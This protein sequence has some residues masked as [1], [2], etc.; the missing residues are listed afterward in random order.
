MDVI[1]QTASNG[2]GKSLEQV[3]SEGY[4]FNF[5]NYMSKGFSLFGNDA[6]MY[7]AYALLYLVINMIVGSIPV[8][9]IFG[10][11]ALSPALTVGWYIYARNHNL[12]ATRSFNNFFEGFNRNWV[13]LI[14]QNIIT[15]IFVGVAAAIVIVPFFLGSFV[16]LIAHA[17][18]LERAQGDQEAAMQILSQMLSSGVVM[19]ILLGGLVALAVATLYVYAPMFIVFRNMQFWDAMEASRKVVSKRYIQTMLFMVVLGIMVGL[20]FI[21]CCLPILAALP[22]MY[23]AIY[24]AYEDIMGT[25]DQA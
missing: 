16:D 1:D 7:L 21:L 10:S 2:Q 24:A 20:A 25:G 5:G 6:A 19:G 18:D 8:V 22:I 11:L 15:S 14:L 17:D 4:E 9:S 13:Q 3:L 23:I 12:G